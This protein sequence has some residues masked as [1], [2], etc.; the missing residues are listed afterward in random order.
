MILITDLALADVHVGYCPFS[1]SNDVLVVTHLMI[2]PVHK[3]AVG[4][5]HADRGMSL[6]YST[7]LHTIL[8]LLVYTPSVTL[9]IAM[10]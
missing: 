9:I 4:L 7:A 5:I 8:A 10:Q 3:A 2:F 6:R 1:Y